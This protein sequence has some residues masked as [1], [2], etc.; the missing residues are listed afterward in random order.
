MFYHM[1]GAMQGLN[2]FDFVLHQLH[3]EHQIGIQYFWQN[4]HR[5]L[6]IAVGNTFVEMTLTVFVD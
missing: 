6:T 3:A 1:L 5:H 2:H 4:D